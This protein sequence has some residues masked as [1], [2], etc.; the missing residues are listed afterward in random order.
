MA[1]NFGPDQTKA[2]RRMST[3]LHAGFLDLSPEYKEAKK[4]RQVSWMLENLGKAL[5]MKVCHAGHA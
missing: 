5:K 2:N 3:N 1:E 4:K